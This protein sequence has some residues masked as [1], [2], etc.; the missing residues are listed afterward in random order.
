LAE[1]YPVFYFLRNTH[2][3][4]ERKRRSERRTEKKGRTER[5][6]KRERMTKKGG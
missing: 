3:G 6:G 2:L 5:R 1:E 4:R